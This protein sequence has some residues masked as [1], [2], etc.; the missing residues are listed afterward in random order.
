MFRKLWAF[1][2]ISKTAVAKCGRLLSIRAD[3]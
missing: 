2:A 3:S 1:G